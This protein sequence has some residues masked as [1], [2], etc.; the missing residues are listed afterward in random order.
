[1]N[2]SSAIPQLDHSSFVPFYVQIKEH[3]KT[4]IEGGILQPGALL[5]SEAELCSHYGISRTVVRQ[6]LQELEYDGLIYRRRGKGS[7]VAERKVH[8]RLV[9]RLTGFYQDMVDQG[10][11]VDNRI[12]RQNLASAGADVGRYLEIDPAEQVIIC[13]RLRLVD[14]KS[15]NFSVSHVPHARCSALLEADLSHQSLYAFIERTCRQPITRGRRT[16]EAILPTPQLAQLLDIDTDLPVF[17]ITSTCYLADGTPIEHSRGYDRSDR[18]LFEVELLR[19]VDD[20]L[21]TSYRLI[22]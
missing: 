12:L 2:Q 14:G 22:G 5:P 16:I 13:E 4:Q 10:H 1:M 18:S 6:A 3:L 20:D 8:E 15:V 21:P 19:G 17:K 9:Q 11:Q 7:F